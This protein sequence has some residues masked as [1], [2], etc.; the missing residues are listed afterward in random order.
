MNEQHH[1]KYVISDGTGN[2]VGY[3]DNVFEARYLADREENGAIG[4]HIGNGDYEF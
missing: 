4:I 2:Y 3:T 1:E